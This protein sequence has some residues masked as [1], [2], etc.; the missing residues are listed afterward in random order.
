MRDQGYQRP[1]EANAV[2]HGKRSGP[3]EWFTEPPKKALCRTGWFE[4]AVCVLS[5]AQLCSASIPSLQVLPRRRKFKQGV[6]NRNAWLSRSTT[7]RT[8]SRCKCRANNRNE[9]PLALL[10]SGTPIRK[11][12]NRVRGLKPC[13][14]AMPEVSFSMPYSLAQC[15]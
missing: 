6:I 8:D 10:I 15:R 3:G 11:R 14:Q 5:D 1:A 9:F 2:V 7:V 12:A 13:H 4:T